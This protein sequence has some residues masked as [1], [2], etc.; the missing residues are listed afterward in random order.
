MSNYSRLVNLIKQAGAGAVAA[1]NP[2]AVYVGSVSAINPLAVTVDQRFTLPEDFL[3][4]PESLTH[5]EI[6]MRHNH[7][8]TDSSDSGST[9]RMT[10]PALPEEPL[11]IRRGLEI[12]DK[13]IMLRVQGG[14]QYVVLDRVV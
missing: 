11:I 10:E 12:G 9:T 6:S 7:S 2:L 1:D 14:Q 13:L 8:Y 4:I 5:Y 3:I